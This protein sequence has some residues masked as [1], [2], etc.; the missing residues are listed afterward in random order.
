[1]RQGIGESAVY[2]ERYISTYFSRNTHL[3][4]EALALFFCRRAVSTSSKGRLSGATTD[5][6]YCCRSQ[7]GR[8]APMVFTSS[9]P[10]ITTFMRSDMFLY[11]RV[12]ASRNGIAIPPDYDAV[13]TRMAD[14]LASIGG[15]G[16]APSFGDDDGGRLFDGRRNRREHMLDPLATAA[17]LFARPDWK[18][19]AGSL[20]EESI[21]LLGLPGMERFG[22][23]PAHPKPQHSRSFVASGY[24]V[25]NSSDAVLVVDAGPHGWAKGGHGHADAL[26]LQLHR[27]WS[28]VAY[29]SRNMFVSE[30]K[31]RPRPFPGYGGTQYARGGRT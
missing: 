18:A 2:I 10:S 15:G 25:L 27:A 22:Q 16:Q 4:G 6:A 5:G 17:T 20:R 13:L 11:A 3:L 8:C 1:M 30:R 23:L 28:R 29:G 26:S 7:A 31:A 12:L 14:A 9:S 21:W 24:Y 19:L